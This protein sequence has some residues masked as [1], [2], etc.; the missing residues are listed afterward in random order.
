MPSACTLQYK[1]N[2]RRAI[3]ATEVL[4]ISPAML[5]LTALFVRN[6]TPKQLEPARTAQAVVM[7]YAARPHVGLWLLLILMPLAVLV[8]GGGTLLHAWS[9]DA[10]LRDAA[11][12]TLAAMR[13]H[14]SMV[15]VAAATLFSA[16]SL[17]C[18]ALHVMVD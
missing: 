4:L 13:A 12:R 17:A 7:L 18:I 9:E 2:M 3:A 8:I 1:V 15:F 5:F 14:L 6:L 10:A 16:F 11:R